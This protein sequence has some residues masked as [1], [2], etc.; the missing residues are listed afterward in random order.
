[1]RRFRGTPWL[2][3]SMRARVDVPDETG[4]GRGGGWGSGGASNGMGYRL[5]I[6]LLLYGIS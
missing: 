1:M 5:P 3:S 2:P 6:M 4:G